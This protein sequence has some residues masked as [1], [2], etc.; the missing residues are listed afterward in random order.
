MAVVGEMREQPSDENHDVFAFRFDLEALSN[1][2]EQRRR[3]NSHSLER[4]FEARR[5]P[6]R[7]R[8]QEGDAGIVN[9]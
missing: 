2:L 6:S 5:N 9:V 4:T 7:G 1:I 3:S 8:L